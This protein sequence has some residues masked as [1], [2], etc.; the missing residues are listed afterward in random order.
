MRLT[1]RWR[2]DPDRRMRHGH[3][4]A[5]SFDSTCTTGSANRSRT[6]AVQSLGLRGTDR[7]SHRLAHY[8]WQR[9]GKSRCTHAVASQFE[10]LEACL[11]SSMMHTSQV[12]RQT[13]GSLHPR[14][15]HEEGCDGALTPASRSWCAWRVT[16]S[17]T[18]ARAWPQASSAFGPPAARVVM[19]AVFDIGKIRIYLAPLTPPAK[20]GLAVSTYEI[21][22][23]NAA[24]PCL[25]AQRCGQV[26]LT[27]GVQ[28]LPD[29]GPMP[30]P[31]SLPLL[32]ADRGL[33]VSS[34][35][36]TMLVRRPKPRCR[37]CD[38][39]CA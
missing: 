37:L 6:L 31:S 30:T 15:A 24:E 19:S 4:D 5:G 10:R 26:A 21:I 16:R 13:A 25:T 39:M 3:Q 23:T 34:W 9:R 27:S 29:G 18:W 28:R 11:S 32:R 22:G 33:A 2:S 36:T 1:R 35:T 8:S 12:R 14:A 20:R 17:S 38:G 7:F